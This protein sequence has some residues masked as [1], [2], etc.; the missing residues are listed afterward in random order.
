MKNTVLDLVAKSAYLSSMI[1]LVVR[2]IRAL[3]MLVLLVSVPIGTAAGMELHSLMNKH[4]IESDFREAADLPDVPCCS[5][6]LGS[7][8]CTALCAVVNDQESISLQNWNGFQARIGVALLGSGIEPDPSRR[9]PR[10][11]LFWGG[12]PYRT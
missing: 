9:P 8:T 5:V 1:N 4:M 12:M 10:L 7:S 11:H 6:E 3:L 2:N